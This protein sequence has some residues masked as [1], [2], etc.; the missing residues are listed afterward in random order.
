MNTVVSG[1]QS[2][3]LLNFENRPQ[4]KYSKLSAMLSVSHL[5]HKFLSLKGTKW[6]IHP[7]LCMT[8][9]LV[10]IVAP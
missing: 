7:G 4:K 2:G 1:G 9:I 3:T 10:G 6:K 5:I 8:V